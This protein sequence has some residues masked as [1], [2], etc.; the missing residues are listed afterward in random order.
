MFIYCLFFI[1]LFIWSFIQEIDWMFTLW[2][3]K[4]Y[5]PRCL[6][7]DFESY[8]NARLILMSLGLICPLQPIF[9]LVARVIFFYYY[10]KH[11][12]GP[13]QSYLVILFPW[14][15]FLPSYWPLTV[16]KIQGLS[17]LLWDLCACYLL[18]LDLHSLIFLYTWPLPSQIG[19]S[20]RPNTRRRPS[21]S[22][23]QNVMRK[24]L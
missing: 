11:I 23:Y 8:S 12:S 20:R 14:I 13:C 10:F 21:D 7:V 19:L 1:H 9:L 16:P 15:N 3:I 4:M 22:I 18:I 6:N 24:S 5:T 17:D 2:L